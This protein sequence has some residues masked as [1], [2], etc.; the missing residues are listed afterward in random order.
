M[1]IKGCVQCNPVYVEKILPRTGLELAIARSVGQSSTHGAT[2][3]S[4]ELDFI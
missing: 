1:I 2:G 3:V 4:L